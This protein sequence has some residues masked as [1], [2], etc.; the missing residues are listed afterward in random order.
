MKRIRIALIAHD[1]KKDDIVAFVTRHRDFLCTCDLVATGNTGRYLNDALDM[2]VTHVLSGPL[3]GDL[4][5]GAQLVDG[6]VAALFFLRDPL[7]PIPHEAD[8]LAL[9]RLCDVYNVPYATNLASAE[10]IIR[11]L[12]VRSMSYRR[13]R[14]LRPTVH[15][16]Q[17]QANQLMKEGA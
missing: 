2:T 4:Q 9:L 15:Q 8:V 11:S 6:V 10:L 12:K 16:R 14:G 1:I 7:T 5:I 17:A 13:Q 3:G